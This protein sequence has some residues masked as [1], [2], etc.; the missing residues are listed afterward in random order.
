MNDR[1]AGDR[2][3]TMQNVAFQTL[4][5][6]ILLPGYK[7]V[8][9]L[10]RRCTLALIA[11]AALA[12]CA[13]EP[14]PAGNGNYVIETGISYKLGAG[15]KIRVVVFREPTLSGE[16][17]ISNNG[18]VALPLIGDIKAGGLT[19]GALQGAI[20]DK[21]A[22]SGMVLQPRVSTDIVSYRPFYILG[23]V[24][25][26]GQYSYAIGM[27][28]TKAVATAGGFTY[29]ANKQTAYIT[30]EGEAEEQLLTVTAATW[31]GPGDT[32]RIAERAF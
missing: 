13:T 31:I 26:P 32:V 10:L 28:V 29:R 24:N 12:S 25:K 22:S 21:L 7:A 27:T 1:T 30:R 17:L 4:W 15:D 16:Y 19:L 18:S 5:S 9:S 14:L 8:S 3:L 11:T 23:E 2:K 6:S 20:T